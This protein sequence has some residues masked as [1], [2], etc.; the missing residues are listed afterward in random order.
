MKIYHIVISMTVIL[1]LLFLLTPLYRKRENKNTDAERK[2][3]EL[4][5]QFSNEPNDALMTQLKEYA[6]LVYGNNGFEERIKRDLEVFT[7]T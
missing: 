1:A 3:F 6:K 4:L 5:K 7:N 2:Y